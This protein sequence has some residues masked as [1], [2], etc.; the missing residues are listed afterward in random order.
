VPAE[1]AAALGDQQA[2]CSPSVTGGPP[3]F[4]LTT[5]AAHV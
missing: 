4:T 1:I 3:R 5:A 2:P